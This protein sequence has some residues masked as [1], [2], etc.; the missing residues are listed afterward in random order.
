[1]IH[2]DIKSGNV[3]VDSLGQPK[4]LDFGIA[5]SMQSADDCTRP[6]DRFLSPQSAAPEQLRGDSV[7]VACDVYALGSLA[8]ELLCGYLPLELAGC[9][10]AEFERRLL[11]VPP[12][13]MSQRLQASDQAPARERGGLDVRGLR[14]QLR[15]DLDAIVAR[16]LRKEPGE[17][18]ASVAQ[19]DED[20]GRVLQR[21]PISIRAG[22]GWYRARKFIARHRLGTGLGAALAA[23][24]AISS[25]LIARQSMEV[26]RQRLQAV[27]ERMWRRKWSKC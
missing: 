24:L 8:F 19:L 7:G 14:A 13:L 22:D 5:K 10:A 4:L 18:Y 21:Q 16:C 3:L 25:V 23:T 12:P 2:R 9:S 11:S 17:R 15:G 20:L 6:A 27:H 26:E 1:V